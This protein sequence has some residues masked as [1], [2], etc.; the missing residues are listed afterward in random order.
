M[1]HIDLQGTVSAT[2]SRP[3][4]FSRQARCTIDRAS[5][6][7]SSKGESDRELENANFFAFLR[8]SIAVR[9]S[10]T[11]TNGTEW[12]MRMQYVRGTAAIE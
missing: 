3:W 10:S 6:F 7:P 4:Y 1:L 9:R 5:L 12:E 2:A 11:R 8:A